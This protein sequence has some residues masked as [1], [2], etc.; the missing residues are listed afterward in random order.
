MS[1]LASVIIVAFHMQ[2]QG[3]HYRLLK[4][5]NQ[6]FGVL[7]YIILYV[8]LA[9]LVWLI[10]RLIK[11]NPKGFIAK[12]QFVFRG[13]LVVIIL[14]VATSIYGLMHAREIKITRYEVTIDKEVEGRESLRI[15]LVADQHL[16][17][18]IGYE[19]M[20][21]M[22]SLINQSNPDL[23][24]FAGDIFDNNFD[25]LD[26]EDGIR[27]A[28]ASINSTLGVYSSWGNHDVEEPLFSG[29]SVGEK[30]GAIRDPRMGEFLSSAGFN[31][32]EDSSIL[33][34]DEFYLVGR[35]DYQKAGDGTNHRK[36]ISELTEDMDKSKP[37]ILIDHQPREFEEIAEAGVDLDLSGHTHA[38]Q[39]FPMNLTNHLT[40]KNGY[41]LMEIDDLTSIVT[42]GVGVYG[43][44]MRVF[45]DNEVVI[46][47]VFFN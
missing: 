45:T 21:K 3:T 4:L 10:L 18:S 9:D 42:S 23:V 14:I 24:C 39:M 7:F 12:N 26:D 19:H 30:G 34:N 16:G 1:S 29:F 28:F 17:Y 15:A 27:E 38:G 20:E 25:A 8:A 6:W 46:I 33:V 40:W 41:G 32:L 47:D 31:L 35:L 37:I 22:V 2:E 44:A 11:K 13:G 43:P 36:S 5:S